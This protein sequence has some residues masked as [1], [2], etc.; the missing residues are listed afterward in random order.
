MSSFDQASRLTF[1]WAT[2]GRRRS[3]Q[4]RSDNFYPAVWEPGTAVAMAGF[5]PAS[6]CFQDMADESPDWPQELR[7]LPR[8]LSAEAAR[9]P[10]GYVYEIDGSQVTN[11]DGYVPPEAIIGAYA[12][13]P[14]GTATGEYLRNPG[15]GPVRDD[16]I[17][18]DSPDHWLGWLPDSPAVAVRAE[19]ARALAEQIA[20][21]VLDW[22]KV[23][24]E[25]AFLTGAVRSADDS[26][27]VTVRRAAVAVPFAL[28]AHSPGKKPAILT[29]VL[30][31]VATGL[32]EPGSRRDRVW[33]DL[34][35]RRADAEGLL[36][37]RIYEPDQT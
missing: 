26:D 18:L 14:D 23:V 15:H 5:G 17:R 20:G 29:G 27:V 8:Q 10:G 28:A 3:G 32:D 13:G 24:D 36:R 7:E 33:F 25:P 22:V 34:G 37:S 19:L 21:T 4:H 9:H 31:W 6:L 1:T 12:V 16:F 30:S 35:M 11:P 2:N